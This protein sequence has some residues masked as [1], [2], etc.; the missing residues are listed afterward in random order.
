MNMGIGP[1]KRQSL[2]VEHC[3]DDMLLFPAN[4]HPQVKLTASA[5]EPLQDAGN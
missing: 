5:A 2:N 1:I 3:K 4:I